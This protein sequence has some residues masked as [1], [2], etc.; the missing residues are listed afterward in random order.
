MFPNDCRQ[1]SKAHAERTVRPRKKTWTARANWQTTSI[2]C[3]AG[4]MK[5]RRAETASSKAINKVNNRARN[6]DN[7]VSGDKR[8]S[9]VNKVNPVNRAS[10]ARASKVRKTVSNKAVNKPAARKTAETLAAAG[11]GLDHNG[12]QWAATG[13][14]IVNF[15][16]KC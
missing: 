10:K 9:R 13:A 12:G 5:T 1:Q 11:N 2:R 14:T 6:R 3:A 4:W 8:G 15:P 16:L 7:K